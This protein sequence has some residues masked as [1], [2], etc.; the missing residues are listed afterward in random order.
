MPL[1]QREARK[2]HLYSWQPRV[3]P[4]IRGSVTREEG[5]SNRLALA[6]SGIRYLDHVNV[7][8]SLPLHTNQ[9]VEP[10]LLLTLVISGDGE[11]QKALLVSHLAVHNCMSYGE[12]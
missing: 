4:N 10:I 7:F 9:A 11:R 12:G 8:P 5:K 6:G 3:Q 2:C 1:L